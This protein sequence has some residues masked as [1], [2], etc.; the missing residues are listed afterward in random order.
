MADEGLTTGRSKLPLIAGVTALAVVAVVVGVAIWR[1]AGSAPAADAS[2]T[3]APESTSTAKTSVQDA[4]AKALEV[5]NAFR[6]AYATASVTSDAANA[7][8]PRYAID[9]AL[10]ETKLD[11]FQKNRLGLIS[12]GKPSWSAKVTSVNLTAKPNTV[13]LT[14]CLD[15]SNWHT[16][17]KDSGKSADAPGQA[18]RYVVAAQ[19]VQGN[20][21][22]WVIQKAT[23][24]RKTPC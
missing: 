9:P 19:A 5:Y 7:E 13:D 4:S 20:D 6:E 8:L 23:A 10:A 3:D 18:Q 21:G 22:R 11:L 14:D 17:Y 2:L 24:D 16:V 1:S 12:S 15:I